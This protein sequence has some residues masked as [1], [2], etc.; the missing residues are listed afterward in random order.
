MHA[1]QNILFCSKVSS[2]IFFEQLGRTTAV[3]RTDALQLYFSINDFVL[4]F[5]CESG[6]LFLAESLR[7]LLEAQLVLL[8]IWVAELKSSICTSAQN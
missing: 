2:L 1:G 4:W 7:V 8:G 6:L 5:Y 3:R